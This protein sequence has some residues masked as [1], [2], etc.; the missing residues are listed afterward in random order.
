MSQVRSAVAP[1]HCIDALLFEACS[2]Y[3]YGVMRSVHRVDEVLLVF[4]RTLLSGTAPISNRA[5]PSSDC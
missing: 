1:L 4:S 5:L 3:G 2:C